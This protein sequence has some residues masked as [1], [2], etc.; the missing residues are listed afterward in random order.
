[1]SK[2]EEVIEAARRNGIQL[3]RFIYVGL[4]G[5]LRAKASYLDELAD[6]LMH[7]IGLT[8]A[9]QS[10]TALDTI[11]AEPRFGPESED[12]FLVPDLETFSPITYSHGQGRVICDMRLRDGG[13]WDFC[14]RS[15]L[16]RLLRKYQEEI[17]VSFQSAA[18]IEFYVLRQV[19]PDKIEPVDWARC[20]STVGYDTLGDI[21][22][23][24]I[25]ALKASGISVVRFIKEYGPGQLE[26]VMRHRDALRAADD[27]VVLRDAAKGV[28]AKHGLV[29]TF[30]AKPFDWHAGSGMHL[31]ISA[32][33]SKTGRNAFYDKNDKRGL[34]LSKMAYHFI[35]GIL[36][37]MKALSAIVA[38]TVNSYKRLIPGSWA[39]SNICY[40]Y[41]NRSAA[42]RIP[43]ARVGKEESNMRIE[44]RTPD[45]AANPYLAL[46]AT[47]AAGVHGIREEMEP[48]EPVNVDAYKLSEE[49]R[50]RRNIELLPGSLREALSFL[51]RDSYL[52]AELG[53]DLVE[54]YIKI[55][56]FE[57]D[58]YDRYVSPWEIKNYVPA[59]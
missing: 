35:G 46:A 43:T 51:G 40:G 11:L 19:A 10:F 47:L 4:D 52:K 8:M 32:L 57:C 31:H 17:G 26:I 13:E 49:E 3:V 56:K 58:M 9:M 23:E 24:I 44:F 30:I 55:K 50:A 5:V 12:I 41:N 48:G 45:P 36:H 37:H 1:M 22:L 28:A 39:P 42:I 6:H 59:F 27:V 33:N 38:P 7:G 14:T 2:L 34:N 18:E 25:N 20:F 21:T 29:A 54:E 16:R 15:L 53:P